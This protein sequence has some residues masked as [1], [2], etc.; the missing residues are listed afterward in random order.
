MSSRMLRTTAA[1]FA[2]LAL[3]TPFAAARQ[4]R[5]NVTNFDFTPRYAS[6]SQGD[7]AVW[8]WDTTPH[9][10]TQGDTANVPVTPTPGTAKFNSGDAAISG[11]S[12][13]TS[14]A[15]SWKANAT[16]LIEYY[17]IPH[18]P[19]MV[20]GLDVVASG[21]QGLSDFRIT[22]VQ[23]NV[24]GN[25]DLI[26]ITNLGA[27]GDLGMYRLKVS[28]AGAATGNL[29][30][31]GSSRTLPVAAGAKFIVHLNASGINDANNLYLSGITGLPDAAGSVAL[32]VP[33]SVN[34]SLA[35]SS[36]LIDFVSW[37]S[38][39][40]ENE[41]TAVSASLWSTSTAVPLVNP[42]SSIEFCGQ[43]GQY[44][45]A[46]WYENPTPNFGGSDNCLTPVTPTTW[47]RIKVLFR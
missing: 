43:G 39:G 19:A 46:R 5:I 6:M 23:Y 14:A 28:G 31:N 32:Y 25:A 36:M 3:A 11:N 35:L 24:A 47:G 16:G 37:G 34:T 15:Y 27:T 41:A 26:E 33:N 12:G 2:L 21:A 7:H 44:G 20:G 42:G 30:R 9:T 10:V 18:W 40:Q 8:I 13:P 22:E 1:A 45:A 38:G 29:L 4:I 17:C